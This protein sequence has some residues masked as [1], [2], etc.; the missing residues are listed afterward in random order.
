MREAGILVQPS[1]SLDFTDPWGNH[2]QVVAYQ[3][4]Q[5]TKS[6]EIQRAMGLDGLGKGEQATEELRAK[7]V[8]GGPSRA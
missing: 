4:V 2:V 8:A 1:G 7:G 3:D 5:Y 6:P